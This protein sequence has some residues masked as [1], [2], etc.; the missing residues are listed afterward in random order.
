MRVRPR[1]CC[2]VLAAAGCGTPF[3]R[4]MTAQ[5]AVSYQS[6]EALLAYLGQPDASPTICDV[7]A[8]GPHGVPG[9]QR[10]RG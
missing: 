9:T 4:P 3:P 8:R 2:L 5:D 1:L 10:S 7:R 6:P